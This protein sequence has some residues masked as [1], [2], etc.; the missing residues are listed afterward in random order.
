MT[1]ESSPTGPPGEPAGLALG[2]SARV[3]RIV[4][5]DDTARA[6]GSGTLDVLGTPRLLAWMEATTVAVISGVLTHAQSSVGTRVSLEHLVASPIG[7]RLSLVATVDH[8]D[9]RLVRMEVVAQNAGGQLV[10]RAQ[11]TR[12]IVEVDRFLARL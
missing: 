1:D 3:D 4:T 9:G 12:V 2:R 5:D 6:L 10:G 11:I 8:L 7:T